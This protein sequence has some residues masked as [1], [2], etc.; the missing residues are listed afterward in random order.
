MTSLTFSL[1]VTW[2]AF[3]LGA[4][5]GAIIG[6]FFKDEKWLGGYGS[7]E[8]RMVRLSHIAWI[9]V[10]LIN[11]S[12]VV[13]ATH[14]GVE[15][16]TVSILLLIANIAMPL[17]CMLTAWRKYFYWLFPVPVFSILAA[18]SLIVPFILDNP[19]VVGS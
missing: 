11:L 13:T 14:I 18:V 5:S 12:W 16:W 1:L 15:S 6:W 8:R 19:P 4:L 10:G 3:A 2:L 17:V 7:R 9:G